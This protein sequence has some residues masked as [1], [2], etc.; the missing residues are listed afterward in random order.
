MEQRNHCCCVTQGWKEWPPDH[1]VGSTT[2]GPHLHGLCIYQ[3]LI[4][5]SAPPWSLHTYS[6][7]DISVLLTVLQHLH[8]IY[9]S[10][11]IDISY[12]SAPPWSIHTYLQQYRYLYKY[13]TY[14]SIDNLYDSAPP[15]CTRWCSCWRSLSRPRTPPPSSPWGT[16]PPESGCCTPGNHSRQVPAIDSKMSKQV[17][18]DNFS[19]YDM[20][21]QR[22]LN[23]QKPGWL[24]HHWRIP[25]I[26]W[27]ITRVA[28]DSKIGKEWIKIICHSRRCFFIQQSVPQRDLKTWNHQKSG[29]LLHHWRKNTSDWLVDWL[30]GRVNTTTEGG[31]KRNIPPKKEKENTPWR[32]TLL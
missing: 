28:I 32:D 4:W 5:Y 19:H 14:S 11:S 22:D 6:I 15:C 24:L 20:L 1:T 7:I 3:Y 30:Q 16:S 10:S 26:D 29:W 12:Y 9:T 31:I 8:G 17:N 18:Q 13:R 23:H 25:A 2:T 21:P 27:L